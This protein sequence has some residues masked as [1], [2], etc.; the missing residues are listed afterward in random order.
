MNIKVAKTNQNSKMI[1]GGSKAM[2]NDF[3]K[4]FCR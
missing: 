1:M 2:T 3:R 4:Y